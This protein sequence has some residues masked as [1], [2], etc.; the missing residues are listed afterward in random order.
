MQIARTEVGMNPMHW[1]KRVHLAA[2]NILGLFTMVYHIAREKMAARKCPELR[3]LAQLDDLAWKLALLTRQFELMRRRFERF[4]PYKR[5][6]FAPED[7]FEV[8]Q[9]IRLAGWST[10]QAAQI[11]VT[12]PNTIRA[13]RRG[14]EGG[15]QERLLG[16]P[17]FNKLG[18][19]VRWL[20]HEIRELC[21][22]SDFGTRT[23][24]MMIVRAGI[25]I[26]RSSVQRV[27]REK[28]PAPAT[29]A[30]KEAAY[31]PHMPFHIL[32]P[33]AIKRTW[34]LDLTTFEFF[35]LR[36]YVAAL[37][38]GFSRKL[39]ALRVYHAAPSTADMLGFVR[40][41]AKE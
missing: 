12:H 19:A 24:A 13:W 27:L 41:C 2:L 34:H 15:N 7:R 18:D 10:R 5:P 11:L 40:Q 23:I 3:Q 25:Q 35:W 31:A 6:D 38:D 14:L 28:K 1:P 22:N 37:V 32:R 29:S 26:S 21:P 20:V 4:N 30:P 39:L 17:P 33:Q 9:L 8:L 36:V 16:R